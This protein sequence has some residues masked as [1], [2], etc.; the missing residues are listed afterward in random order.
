MRLA[1]TRAGWRAHA[2]RGE[3]DARRMK[4]L[5]NLADALEADANWREALPARE[6]VLAAAKKHWHAG[7]GAINAMNANVASLR[8]R[9]GR[10]GDA[11][12]LLRSCYESEVRAHGP[13]HERSFAL[14]L[15][16][17]AAAGDRGLGGRDVDELRAVLAR[18]RRALG[19]RHET[20]IT[21][22]LVLAKALLLPRGND[23]GPGPTIDLGRNHD[24]ARALLDA[25]LEDARVVFGD[26]HPTYVLFCLFRARAAEERD[27]YHEESKGGDVVHEA[28]APAPA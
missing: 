22:G 12:A 6:A 23:P 7:E 19:P 25:C 13:D 4:S 26:G 24:E 28:P 16:M 8:L 18:A 2:R 21:L 1:M 3:D 27:A 5:M 15:D 14:F 10:A 20:A 17:C 11:A 9:L